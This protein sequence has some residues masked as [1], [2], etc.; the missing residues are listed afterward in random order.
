MYRTH[1]DAAYRHI[2]NTTDGP[3]TQY[4]MIARAIKFAPGGDGEPC[5]ADYCVA[6][7]VAEALYDA[8]QDHR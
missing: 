1:Y 6:D 2:T 5:G 3:L 8:L 7:A 4:V